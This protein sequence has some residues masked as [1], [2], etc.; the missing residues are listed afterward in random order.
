MCTAVSL[1]GLVPHCEA[2]HPGVNK[3]INFPFLR[4]RGRGP[5]LGRGPLTRARQVPRPAQSLQEL[6]RRPCYVEN[7][8]H[9]REGLAPLDLTL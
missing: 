7:H 1:A 3:G 2:S 5:G 6:R 8:S 9:G 4:R